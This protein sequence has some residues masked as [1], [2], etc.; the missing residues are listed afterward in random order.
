MIMTKNW[1]NGGSHMV[2][3]VGPMICGKRGYVCEVKKK[4][5]SSHISLIQKRI[6]FADLRHMFP[7]SRLCLCDDGDC[8][9]DGEELERKKAQNKS[10]HVNLSSLFI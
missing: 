8:G 2:S 6:R 4:E 9:G 10:T 5:K 1:M 3:W 7:Q